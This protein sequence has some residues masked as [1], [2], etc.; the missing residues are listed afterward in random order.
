MLDDKSYLVEKV[1]YFDGIKGIE[2]IDVFSSLSTDDF[3]STVI[4]S[5][6]SRLEILIVLAVW[7]KTCRLNRKKEWIPNYNLG[8]MIGVDFRRC[9]TAKNKLF[10][11][12]VLVQ[13]GRKIGINKNISEWIK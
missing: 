9:S 6:F 11:K 8:C 2:V 5:N 13:E 4:S 1:N 12:K 10:S 7:L 3:I